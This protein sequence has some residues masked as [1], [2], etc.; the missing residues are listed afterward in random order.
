MVRS[1]DPLFHVVVMLGAA[2]AVVACGETARPHGGNA[3][4]AGEGAGSATGGGGDAGG[5]SPQL[6]TPG[7][8]GQDAIVTTAGTRNDP[9]S[10]GGQTGAVPQGD[11]SAGEAAG[12]ADCPPQQLR[13]AS[14]SPAPTDCSCNRNAP[15]SACDCRS[16]NWTDWTCAVFDPPTGCE[17]VGYI[18]GPR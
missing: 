3:G 13:C 17:C 14:Y 7:A 4:S 1:R 9:C 8:A 5:D 10:G 12:L 6:V 15:L 16:G 18:T 11:G 2:A